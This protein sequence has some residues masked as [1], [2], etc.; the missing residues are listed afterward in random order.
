MFVWNFPGCM[1]FT[2]WLLANQILRPGL[3][4]LVIN[5]LY[6][7]AISQSGCRKAGLY[8]LPLMDKIVLEW[9]KLCSNANMHRYCI[10]G[11][12]AC[13]NTLDGKFVSGHVCFSSLLAPTFTGRFEHVSMSTTD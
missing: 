9:P 10:L 1:E 3:Y 11:S 12:C 2:D 7:L 5:M 4:E 6:G 13:M 8:Q